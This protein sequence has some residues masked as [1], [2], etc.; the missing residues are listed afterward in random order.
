MR[1]R[2]KF[3][4]TAVTLAIGLTVVYRLPQETDVMVRYGFV[5]ILTVLTW[6]MAAWSLKEGLEGVEWLTVLTPPAVLTASVGLFYI[7][8]PTFWL[9]KIGIIVGFGLLQ[10]FSL[11]TA[12]IYSV[13]AIRTIALLRT[14][15]VMGFVLTLLSGFLLF[16]TIFSLRWEFW[17]VGLTV[18]AV[19]WLLYLPALWAINL[20]SRIGGRTWLYSV[21][22]AVMTGVL[23]IAVSFWPMNL[24]VASLC[25]TTYLYVTLGIASQSLAGRV[26]GKM[27][28]EYI[29]W[30]LVVTFTALVKSFWG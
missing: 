18:A 30:G 27:V 4:L 1:K 15:H 3:V 14:A 2:Q 16:N 29:V 26:L 13:A 24:A 17:W 25:L 9:V 20:E 5:A 8:L 11:L 19:A 22:F 28:W 21:V 6:I 23:G 10:Y 7:L 12:N